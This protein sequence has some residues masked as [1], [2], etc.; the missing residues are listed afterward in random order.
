MAYHS[1]LQELQNDLSNHRGVVHPLLY[2]LDALS[3]DQLKLFASQ[4][5]LYVR[6]FPRL[7][8]AVMFTVPDPNVRIRLLSNLVSEYGGIKAVDKGSLAQS[9]P[10]LFKRFSR[11]IGISDYDLE[12]TRPL[13]STRQ[14]LRS[15][16]K[17]YL[18]SPFLKTLGAVGPGT[19]CVVPQ[20]YVP[21]LKSLKKRKGLLKD[22]LYFFEL[23]LPKDEEHCE[24]MCKAIS[25]YL[26]SEAAR[27]LV[28]KGA[29]EALH[30]R[31]K[32]W[33]G[34]AKAISRVQ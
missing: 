16:E 18:R 25:P 2:R 17:L 15:Y 28:R 3:P 1:F 32:F 24:Q 23:H 14:F 9:H 7:M 33:E 8:G 30:S 10:E 6:S 13:L 19:E 5:Y 26:E 21:M 4:F 12:R 34:L 27:R 11:K 20:M 22:D 31:A 29:E